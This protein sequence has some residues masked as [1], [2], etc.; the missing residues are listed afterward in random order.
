MAV[1]E[2]RTERAMV[3]GLALALAV[4]CAKTPPTRE[5]LKDYPTVPEAKLQGV[6]RTNLDSPT[7]TSA[8]LERKR[9]SEAAV[10]AL[11]LPVLE[12]LPVVEDDA[13]ITPRTTEEVAAR[14]IATTLTGVKGETNDQ[15]LVNKLVADF[16]AESAFS[17]EE[18]AFIKAS[19][20]S[21]PVLVEFSWR[22]EC[23]HVFLWALSFEPALNPP[24]KQ[25]DVAKEF[26][27]IRDK[28]RAAFI[29]DAHLP[30]MKE[31]LDLND[32]YYRLNWAAVDLR[33]KGH[34]SPK[35][36]EE[37]IVERHRALNWLIRYMNQDW[38]D[39]TTDT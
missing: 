19:S 33:L 21:K 6:A 35:A 25:A 10:K 29:R 12:G 4:G 39:V 7:P 13:K 20:P 14:C 23:T 31:L 15:H 9:R 18:R 5:K 8:Q 32:L 22:Y 2:A 37:I 16:S 28:G 11:G 34:P 38:D 24:D 27:I 30:S 3:V 36:N 26:G 1:V 17:P